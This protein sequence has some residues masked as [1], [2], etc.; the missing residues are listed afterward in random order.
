MAV[1]PVSCPSEPNQI[2]YYIILQFLPPI[3]LGSPRASLAPPAEEMF[4]LQPSVVMGGHIGNQSR[5]RRRV[6]RAGPPALDRL[7]FGRELP[8]HGR[9]EKREVSLCAAHTHIAYCT[10][11]CRCI[12]VNLMHM[13]LET[14][15]STF[16]RYGADT[17]DHPHVRTEHMNFQEH[18][19]EHL[20]TDKSNGE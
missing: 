5:N 1:F 10:Y 15:A 19:V 4:P 17:W 7:L 3:S 20:E 12:W 11:M 6:Q 2:F 8:L 18:G 13:G 9:K 14:Q 16:S